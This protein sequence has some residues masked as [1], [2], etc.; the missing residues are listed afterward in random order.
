MDPELF[1]VRNKPVRGRVLFAGTAE[2][3]K[4]IQYFALAV[5]KLVALGLCYEFRVA[6]DV[7]QSVANQKPCRYLTFLGRV[8][9][10]EMAREFAAADLF[11]LRRRLVAP[12]IAGN[13]A[14]D[15]L[16]ML[17]HALHTPEARA[18]VRDGIEGRIVRARDPEST[19]ECNC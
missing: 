12:G 3:R 18:V 17:E 9:R 11:V 2:L 8:P 13:R 10:A 1:S 4:G 6:G 19:R 16:D 15:A 7:R 5:E 14:G